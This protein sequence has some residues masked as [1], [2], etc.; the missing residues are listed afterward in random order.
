MPEDRINHT[1]C[2]A[3]GCEV[4]EEALV[5]PHDKKLSDLSQDLQ[6]SIMCILAERHV[7]SSTFSSSLRSYFPA[8]PLS[9]MTTLGRFSF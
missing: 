8:A 3:E 6:G 5:R 9:A 2:H 7:R 4:K 1:R